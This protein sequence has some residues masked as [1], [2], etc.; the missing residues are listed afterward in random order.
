MNAAPPGHIEIVVNGERRSVPEGQT[1][2]ELLRSLELDPA[3]VAV[4]M[5][6]EILRRERWAETPLRDG[7]CLEIVQFVGGG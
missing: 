4:E 2:L 7:T 5:D 6:R 3:R 1:V